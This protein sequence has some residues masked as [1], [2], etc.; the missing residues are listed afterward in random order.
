MKKLLSLLF[1]LTAFVVTSQ[2]AINLTTTKEYDLNGNVASSTTNTNYISAGN[3]AAVSLSGSGSIVYLRYPLKNQ[4]GTIGSYS[5]ASTP[6]QIQA[7]LTSTAV[8]I[9]VQTAYTTSATVTAAELGGG[10]LVNTG[11]VAITLTLPTA[12]L[13]ATNIGAGIGSSVDFTV[14]NNNASGGTITVAVGSGMT[15]SGFPS[16]NTLTLANSATVGI[17]KFR[18]HFLSATAATLTRIN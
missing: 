10:L 9:P 14:L 6:V 4:N 12:S 2:T 18:I 8:N 3:I 7:L 16:S 1:I 11:T 5:T 17:A 13:I 15:A